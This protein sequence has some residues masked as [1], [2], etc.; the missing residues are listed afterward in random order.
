MRIPG[1]NLALVAISVV[2]TSQ[3]SL[4]SHHHGL[5]ATLVEVQSSAAD[6]GIPLN[7]TLQDLLAEEVVTERTDS[8]F[9][10]Y[11]ANPLAAVAKQK[12]KAIWGLL[13]IPY[14]LVM[15]PFQAAKSL[16]KTGKAIGRPFNATKWGKFYL[17]LRKINRTSAMDKPFG[18]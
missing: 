12:V 13:T 3:E 6:L 4:A 10:R 17:D 16:W 2:L 18:V 1:T 9:E 15:A 8:G 11:L 7:K 14:R 5:K